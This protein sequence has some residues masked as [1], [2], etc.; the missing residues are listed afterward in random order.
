VFHNSSRW[1]NEY[2]LLKKQFYL[3]DNEKDRLNLLHKLKVLYQHFIEDAT[4]IAKT[5]I[6]ESHLPDEKKTVKP[7]L[8]GVAGSLF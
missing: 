3:S 4:E 8:L 1:Q 5:I 6:L 7:L 2:L